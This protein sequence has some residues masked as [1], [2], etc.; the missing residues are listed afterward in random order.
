MYCKSKTSYLLWI[1]FIISVLALYPANS[2]SLRTPPE[3]GERS[4]FF[5]AA[6]SRE[7]AERL[8]NVRRV[9]ASSRGVHR[10]LANSSPK[11]SSPRT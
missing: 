4:P 7:L 5:S 10:E 3:F 9:R 11:N 1:H 2:S 6:N 8:P